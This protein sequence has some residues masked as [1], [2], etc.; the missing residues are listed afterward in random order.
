MIINSEHNSSPSKSASVTEISKDYRTRVCRA[1]FY[2]SIRSQFPPL[3][4]NIRDYTS[5]GSPAG[6]LAGD[7]LIRAGVNSGTSCQ[8]WW[9]TDVLLTCFQRALSEKLHYNRRMWD[10]EISELNI[11]DLCGSP[12]QSPALGFSLFSGHSRS[13][14]TLISQT[15]PFWATV[16]V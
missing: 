8:D 7:P 5:G 13:F 1:E 2:Y 16:F 12:G 11:H 9:I 14:N 6:A 15:L 3:I 4:I 10:L